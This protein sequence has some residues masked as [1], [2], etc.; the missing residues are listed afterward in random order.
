MDLQNALPRRG[1]RHGR[2]ADFRLFSPTL[3]QASMRLNPLQNYARSS[4]IANR[5]AS[6]LPRGGNSSAFRDFAWRAINACVVDGLL[7]SGSDPNL[8]NLRRYVEGDIDGLILKAVERYLTDIAHREARF[9][10]WQ[11]EVRTLVGSLKQGGSVP[12]SRYEYPGGRRGDLLHPV[13]EAEVSGQDDRRDALDHAARSGALLGADQQPHPT[14]R[15]ARFWSLR[16]SSP[17][18]A[19]TPRTCAPSRTSRSSSTRTRS[20]T[21]TS[22]R[23]PIPSSVARSSPCSWPT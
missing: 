20:S 14:A 22:T 8:M 6:L 16:S 21:S 4:Q 18:T 19:M 17:A 11:S 9:P 15:A 7:Q 13:R 1:A 5:I 2:Q 3:P 23:W 12:R 10:G